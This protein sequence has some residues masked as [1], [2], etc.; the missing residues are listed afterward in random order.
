MNVASSVVRHE[1]ECE[2]S[3]LAV[4][5]EVFGSVTIMRSDTDMDTTE[6][7]DIVE[8]QVRPAD[9]RRHDAQSTMPKIV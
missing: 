2:S 7:P 4:D 1:S 6:S 9:H 3:V 5:A 8:A